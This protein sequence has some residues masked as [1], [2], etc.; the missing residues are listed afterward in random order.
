MALLRTIVRAVNKLGVGKSGPSRL[1]GADDP[2][3][4]DQ[5]VDA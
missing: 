5:C 2:G 3:G 1:Y 4:A